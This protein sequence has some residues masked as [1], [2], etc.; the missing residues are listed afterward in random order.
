MTNRSLIKIQAAT[1]AEICT[2]FDL[3]EK[4]LPLLRDGMGPRE[5]VEALLADKQYGAGVNFMA[6]ALPAREAIWW[7]CLCLQHA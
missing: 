1:A 6:H 3:D 7:G 4:L 5:F 2:R